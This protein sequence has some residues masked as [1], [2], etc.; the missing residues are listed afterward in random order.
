MED[1]MFRKSIGLVCFLA[2][3]LC[4]ALTVQAAVPFEDDDTLEEIRQKIEQNGYN[5]TV[6]HTRIFDLPPAVKAEMLSRRASAPRPAA[7]Y[8]L[9]FRELEIPEALPGAY[10]SRDI[11][12]HSYIG[13]IRDQAISGSCYAFGACA[14]AEGAYNKA[15]G[16]MDASVVE[17]S[18]SF[19]MWCLGTYGP[20][21][22]HFNGLGGAD[23]DYAELQALTREGVT[24][25]ADFPY[26]ITDPG[27]CTHW[28]DPRVVFDSWGRC[29]CQAL[30]QI[31][32]AIMQN[33]VVDAAVMVTSAFQAYT[34][35]VYEDTLN[36][37]PAGE[38]E[39]CF[40][41]TTNHAT[42]LVGW[43]D[44]GDPEKEGY[45]I[46]RNSWGDKWG[47]AGYMRIKYNSARVSCA[48]AYVTMGKA[49]ETPAGTTTHYVIFFVLL[50][51]TGSLV[52]IGRRRW[53]S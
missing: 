9:Q 1:C 43:N 21:F 30:D 12:G 34:G 7:E 49:P 11:D 33:G 31:K 42:A 2:L 48:V 47:E 24:F 15:F 20:Y 22:E 23:Y 25:E 29:E 46:L 44:N 45:W 35:G 4:A 40:Y 16:L 32:A 14:A 39:P 51:T 38:G 19:I 10:D 41:T 6:G 8:A 27:S 5:F 53:R 28:E 18:E 3:L 37:C 13:P 26:T 52:L 50:L 17:F 36:G